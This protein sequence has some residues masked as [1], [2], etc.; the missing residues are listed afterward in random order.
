MR[1]RAV[2]WLVLA[3]VKLLGDAT[4]PVA[5]QNA[6]ETPAPAAIL[7]AKHSEVMLP[8]TLV[9]ISYSAFNQCLTPCICHVIPHATCSAL[10][11]LL[12]LGNGQQGFWGL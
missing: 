5:A 7:N 10:F 1:S 9:E 2:G 3:I 11:S 12:G 4:I 8:A 6:A